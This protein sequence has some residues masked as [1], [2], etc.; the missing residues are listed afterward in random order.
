MSDLVMCLKSSLKHN[1]VN[2]N[3]ENKVSNFWNAKKSKLM[4][5]VSFNY[6]SGA[7]S[8]TLWF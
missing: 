6:I 2:I 4:L 1:K 5:I 8:E 7:G 3:F